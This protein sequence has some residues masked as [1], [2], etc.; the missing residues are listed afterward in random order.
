LFALGNR[1]LTT[2]ETLDRVVVSI[3]A[4]AI[5]QSDAEGELRFELF[6]EGKN[7]P[8]EPDWATLQQAAE[9]L[10]DQKLL[11]LEAGPD[12]PGPET[13]RAAALVELE[14][15]KKR[16]PNQEAFA[17]ALRTLG[18]SEAELLERVEAQ[19]RIMKIVDQRLRPA[20]L[21]EASE[22][23]AYYRET[24]V[25]DFARKSAGPV[26]SLTEVESQIREILVQKKINQL[27]PG[28]LEGLKTSHHVRI[29]QF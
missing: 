26:P 21:P 1:S 22:V 10:I 8:G 7:D 15:V 17:S 28:W 5:T 20:A 9:R 12:F 13:F 2:A 16:Y 6:L 29:H 3:G 24:F 25:K 23:E 4:E 27:L 18:M 14:E 11:A 19:Q